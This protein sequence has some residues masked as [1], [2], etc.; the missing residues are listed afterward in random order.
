MEQ[1][2]RAARRVQSILLPKES[3]DIGGLDI[4]IQWRLAREVSGDLFDFFEQN[5]DT[6]VI[7]FGDSSGKGAAAA[8]YGALVS[9]LLR[10]LATRIRRPSALMQR[11]NEILLERKVDAQYV[12]LLLMFWNRQTQELTISNAGGPAPMVCRC[13]ERIRIAVEGIPLGLLESREYDEVTFKAQKG[14][15]LVLYSDGVQD[16][17]NLAEEEY[18]RHRLFK[19]I[20]PACD[21]PPREIVDAVFAD[22]DQHMTG[23]PFT[24]DQSLIAIKVL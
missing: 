22:L 12:T 5:D 3:P 15:V 13:G 2:L 1:D 21:L 10:P 17:L 14:D 11:L 6:A 19:A 4:A 7:A 20:K 18:G 16:Q 9:G 8:L 23:M 24:D